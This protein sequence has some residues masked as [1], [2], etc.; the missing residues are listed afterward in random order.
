MRKTEEAT[1]QAV[2]TQV[3]QD[4]PAP[5]DLDEIRVTSV[6]TNRGGTIPCAA[7]FIV[8]SGAIGRGAVMTDELPNGYDMRPVPAG[9]NIVDE[10]LYKTEQHEDGKEY[11]VTSLGEPLYYETVAHNKKRNEFLDEYREKARKTSP[12][13]QSAEQ[14]QAALKQLPHMIAKG[15]QVHQVK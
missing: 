15:P 2:E 8:M 10:S 4:V 9:S 14:R 6:R 3:P 12:L 5:D 11:L 7:G 1:A 13:I